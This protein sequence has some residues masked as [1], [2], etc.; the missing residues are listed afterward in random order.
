MRRGSRRG[1]CWSA[2]ALFACPCRRARCYC[3]DD[4]ERFDCCVVL[5]R[6]GGAS[7]GSE[8]WLVV[9]HV[10]RMCTHQLQ[11][12]VRTLP[13]ACKINSTGVTSEDMPFPICIG[14]W[15]SRY[16][17]GVETPHIG[18]EQNYVPLVSSCLLSCALASLRDQKLQSLALLTRCARSCILIRT[19]TSVEE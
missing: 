7:L 10:L 13:S 14:R 5:R 17:R 18:E 6:L 16:S 1:K 4:V 3:A 2:S 8:S 19:P 12:R 11:A 15:W 9:S